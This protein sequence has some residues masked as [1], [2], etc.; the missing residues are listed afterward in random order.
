M[1]FEIHNISQAVDFNKGLGSLLDT[2]GDDR[3]PVITVVSL[4]FCDENSSNPLRP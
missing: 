2:V 4:F 1:T 3:P